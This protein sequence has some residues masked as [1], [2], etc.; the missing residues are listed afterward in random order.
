MAVPKP[1]SG[2]VYEVPPTT[3]GEHLLR[4]PDDGYKYDLYEGVL[5]RETTSPGHGESASG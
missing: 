1:T 4:L 2:E 3:T 5:L